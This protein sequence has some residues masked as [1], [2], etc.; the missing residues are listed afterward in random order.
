MFGY[1]ADE[2]I[3]QTIYRLIPPDRI[4]EEPQIISRLK[5]GE[6]VQHFETKRVTKEGR[7]LDVSLSISPVKD[8]HGNIIGV[9]KIARDITE[10]KLEEQRKND[11]IGMV[12]HELKTPL[13]SLNGII[14]VANAKLKHSEDQ[15]LAGYAKGYGTGEKNDLDDQRFSKCLAPGSG[16]NAAGKGADRCEQA[17]VRNP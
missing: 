17:A 10:K 16:Q 3:G 13:T 15:F 12:S 2:I 14:Q 6:R 11:F 1:T 7:L 9:S 8:T 5:N 4:E